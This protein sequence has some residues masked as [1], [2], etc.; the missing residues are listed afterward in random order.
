MLSTCL[1]VWPGMG[2]VPTDIESVI[3]LEALKCRQN[4]I[5]HV[6]FSVEI[7]KG[8]KVLFSFSSLHEHNVLHQ[9]KYL[10]DQAGDYVIKAKVTNMDTP[11][12]SHANSSNRKSQD[13]HL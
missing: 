13:C 8:D 4:L 11:K 12:E 9:I 3:T 7:T 2:S 1:G 6:D 10:F 5:Q